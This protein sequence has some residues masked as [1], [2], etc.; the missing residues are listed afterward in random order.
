MALEELRLV[1]LEDRIEADLVRG[2]GAELVSELSGL[3]AHHPLRERL[4]GT[5]SWRCTAAA[6]AREAYRAARSMLDEE[7]EPSPAPP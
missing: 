1:A 3:V 7:L 6:D 5:R 2:L 4:V